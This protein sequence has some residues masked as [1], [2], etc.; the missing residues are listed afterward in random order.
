VITLRAIAVIACG[1]CA[2]AF[3][4]GRGPTDV[5]DVSSTHE[6]AYAW[7]NITLSPGLYDVNPA[8]TM[9]LEDGVRG[10]VSWRHALR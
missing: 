1:R 2:R 6:R 3:A 4:G 10:F 7:G 8:G 5:Q 9:V